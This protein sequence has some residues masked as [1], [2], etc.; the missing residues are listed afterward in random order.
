[1]VIVPLAA[2]RMDTLQSNN[3]LT[4]DSIDNQQVPA[5]SFEG[6]D[7]TIR[8]RL[9]LREAQFSQAQRMAGMASWEWYF[10]DTTIQW[11]PEMYT[12]WGYEPGEIDVDL[13]SV[14]QSTHLDDLPILQQAISKA[15]SGE[16][17]E[18]EYRRFS[19]TGREIFIRSVGKIIRNDRSEAIGVF[20]IDM[21]VTNYKQQEMKLATLNRQLEEKNRELEMRNSELKSFSYVASHDL[22]E[23]LRKIY[24]FNSLILELDADRLSDMGQNYFRRS[25]AATE[26]MQRLIKDLIAYSQTETGSELRQPVDLGVLFNQVKDEH[27]DA[28]TSTGATFDVA[29]LPTVPVV[30]F[31]FRQLMHNL[32]GNA[33]KYAQ[34]NRPPII[35]LTYEEI[36]GETGI[37][38]FTMPSGRYHK[39]TVADNGIGFDTA[40]SRKIFE[41]FQRLHGRNEYSG[42]GIG[43]AICQR[44]MES[45]KGIIIADG[46]VGEGATF[47]ACWPVS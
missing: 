31:M 33:L 17:V 35:R 8:D 1:M 7:R 22:Q 47:T 26:R 30:E 34:T 18:M 4:L 14:A 45:H 32:V 15:L 12:F 20:G 37:D 19:K 16:D 13:D 28:V 10:G 21:N 27:Q 23:P 25:I 43:L 2:T 9:S 46:R 40:Y 3:P 5:D 11:S 36:V 42:T 38:S 6:D 24:T 39:L 41:L 44:I 29:P